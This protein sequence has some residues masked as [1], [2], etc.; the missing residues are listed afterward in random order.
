MG[1]LR[2]KK[3]FTGS[4]RG[5]LISAAVIGVLAVAAILIIGTIWTGRSVSR[6][7]LSVYAH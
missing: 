3:S 2:S 4:K 5:G 7:A 1:S 6:D